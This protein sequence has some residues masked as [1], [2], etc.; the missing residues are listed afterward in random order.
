MRSRLLKLASFSPEKFGD[1]TL[2]FNITFSYF[3][4]CATTKGVAHLIHL[5]LTT[6]I[7][8]AL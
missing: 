7:G 5:A 3:N 4:R 8:F 6:F 2:T 1:F